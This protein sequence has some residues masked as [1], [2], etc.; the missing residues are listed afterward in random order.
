MKYTKSERNFIFYDVGNSAYILI[1]T[2]MIPIFFNL[3]A[4]EDLDPAT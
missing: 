2:T 1:A 4:K 3:L